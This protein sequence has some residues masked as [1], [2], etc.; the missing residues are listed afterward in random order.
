MKL[1]QTYAEKRELNETLDNLRRKSAA[2][3]G[4]I[5]CHLKNISNLK[6]ERISLKEKVKNLKA[7]ANKLEDKNKELSEKTMAQAKRIHDLENSTTYK[8]G[9]VIMWLP[10]K[11]K[12]LAKKLLKR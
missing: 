5:V 4:E 1:Q 10:Q 12:S 3:N 6:E 2:Q 8:V 9:K 11:L 7:Q